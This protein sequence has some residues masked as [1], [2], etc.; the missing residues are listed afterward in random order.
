MLYVDAD[1]RNESVA[2]SFTGI[3][4]ADGRLF[5]NDAPEVAVPIESA[6]A[7]LRAAELL[8]AYSARIAAVIGDATSVDVVGIGALSDLVRRQLPALVVRA[9]AAPTA[10]AVLT[11]NPRAVIDAF[12]SLAD[13]GTLVLACPGNPGCPLDLYSD[14]H[15]RGLRMVG[16]P[17]PLPGEASSGENTEAISELVTGLVD[18]VA[19]EDAPGGGWFRTTRSTA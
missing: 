3:A 12:G 9:S 7:D 2:T 14:L 16:V 15:R 8:L 11:S 4:V 17:R 5:W 6:D 1:W 13:L 10:V 18:V 19:S